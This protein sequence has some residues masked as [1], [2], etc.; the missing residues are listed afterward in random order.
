MQLYLVFADRRYPRRAILKDEER[1]EKFLGIFG[2]G[3][4]RIRRV[5]GRRDRC[6]GGDGLW[7]EWL[8]SLLSAPLAMAGR[9]AWQILQFRAVRL[10]HGRW[11]A[12]LPLTPVKRSPSFGDFPGRGGC[13]LF[14][15]LSTVVGAVVR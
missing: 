4:A 10:C 7:A 13:P 8:S 3:S 14:P 9:A 5:D 1:Y 6:A 2:R 15:I 12:S 11:P